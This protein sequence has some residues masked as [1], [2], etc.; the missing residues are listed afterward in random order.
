MGSTKI[1]PTGSPQQQALEGSYGDWLKS[2]VGSTA[3]A[4]P[5]QLMADIP[6]G[7]TSAYNTLMSNFG[8]DSGNINQALMR[9]VQ[10]QPAYSSD[11]GAFKGRFQEEFA[12]PVM[13]MWRQTV[14]PMVRGGYAGI[15]GGL[16]SAARG[17]GIENAANQYY[18][19]NVQPEF[20]GAWRE[21]LNRQFQS[22]EAAAGRRQGAVASMGGYEEM[23]MSAGERLRAARQAGLTADYGDFLR[24]APEAS[25]WNQIFQDYLK[26]PTRSIVTKQG[27]QK[28]M[29]GV[30]ALA[31]MA[32]SAFMPG[33]G[34]IPAMMAGSM[35]GGGF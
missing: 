6:Q 13:E 2:F 9:D 23:M 14:E 1:I 16:Y 31:G 24:T 18:A 15:R 3:T 25:P 32:A 7:F 8:R 27:T 30:G 11:F 26:I 21:D 4:Y 5:G 10:G 22:G 28:S 12:A 33:V 19:E 34:A 20:M 35:I 17:R 29:A